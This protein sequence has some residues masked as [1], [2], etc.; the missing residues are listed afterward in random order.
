[1]IQ[2]ADNESTKFSLME[3]FPYGFPEIIN[4][5]ITEP[6]IMYN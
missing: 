6:E 1:M 4:I 3:A 2:E 5:P